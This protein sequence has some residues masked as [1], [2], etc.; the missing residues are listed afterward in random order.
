MK[1]LKKIII[2]LII[3]VA[4]IGVYSMYI[5]PKL[6]RVKDYGTIIDKGERRELKIVQFSD[7]QLGEFFSLEQ[8]E[9]VVE[10]INSTEPDIVIFAGD[11]IDNA[12]QYEE[13][14]KIADVLSKINYKIGKYAVYGNHDYG[15]G[16]VRYYDSIMEQS[17]FKVLKNSSEYIKLEDAN[18]RIFG[19]DEKLMGG[20]NAEETMNG[21]NESDINLLI[22]HEPDLIDDFKDYPID[23]ALAGHSHGG[24]V[25]I[26]F[27][28]PIINNVLSEKYNK[29]FYQLNNERETK[30]YVNTGLGNTKLRP[31]LGN[32]PE[33]TTFIIK[34]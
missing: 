25:Y 7:T 4:I 10:K 13:I 27:Y 5:E 3:I 33:I 31:R 14:S 17:G 23:L 29:G 11:L 1:I 34:I 2:Y 20:Y 6:M 16:A 28:G 21:I 32:I 9:K 22:L 18:I 30:L 15:G 24:Q 12:S 8:L 19:A 26:P